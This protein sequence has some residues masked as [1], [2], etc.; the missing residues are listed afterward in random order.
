MDTLIDIAELADDLRRVTVEVTD[1]DELLG[2]GLLWPP[3][4]VVTNAHVVRRPEVTLRL[5]DGRCL[6]ARVRARD[7]D[8]DLALLSAPGTGA[9][10]TPPGLRRAH[11]FDR[12]PRRGRQRAR[13][14]ARRGHA[15]GPDRIA[16]DGECSGRARAPP[17]G[18]RRRDRRPG[19]RIGGDG[20]A[21][22]GSPQDAE[23][24]RRAPARFGPVGSVDGAGAAVRRAR[25]AS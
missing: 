22:R 9:P 2:S 17:R 1:A 3:G 18:S 23:G 8:A 14:R 4:H 20:A 25:G 10:A 21:A 13:R 24:R 12:G 16:R 6:R 11:A 15:A 5:S 19:A 7:A